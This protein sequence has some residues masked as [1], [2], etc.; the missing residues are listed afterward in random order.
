MRIPPVQPVP[1]DQASAAEKAASS[2]QAAVRE[3]ALPIEEALTDADH[4]VGISL[5]V[6]LPLTDGFPPRVPLVQVAQSAAS[7]DGV[8]DVVGVRPIKPLS[9]WYQEVRRAVESMA[10]GRSAVPVDVLANVLVDVRSD[11]TESLVAAIEQRLGVV[12]IAAEVDLSH[13]GAYSAAW[14]KDFLL[15]TR[16][17]VAVLALTVD[18]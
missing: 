18:D 7:R 4:A 5:V 9:R 16:S 15:V 3:V 2:A 6:A 1:P 11:G 8:A 17:H 14:R 13:D 10:S 12:R